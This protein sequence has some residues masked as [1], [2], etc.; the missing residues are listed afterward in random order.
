MNTDILDRAVHFAVD[1]HSGTERRGK[2]IPYIIHPLEAAAIAATLTDDQ[3]LLAASVL[4][5]V[6]E[7]TSATIGQIRAEFGDRIA[8]LVATESNPREGTW[9]EHRIGAIA[10]ISA[11]S[12]NAKIVA[13]GDKLSNLRAIAR[14]YAEK[15][16]SLWSLFYAPN[17]RDDIEWYYRGLAE[18]MEELSGT[19]AYNEFVRLVAKVFDSKRD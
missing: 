19:D 14:D 9:K 7:D 13:M 3:E 10:R 12:R 1:A 6:V 16:D 2:N 18:A 8:D 4:H 15:G 11:A 17:G 5:D